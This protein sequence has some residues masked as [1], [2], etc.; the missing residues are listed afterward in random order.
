MHTPSIALLGSGLRR[1]Y[2][3]YFAAQGW[4]QR[5]RSPRTSAC[6]G[7]TWSC[8]ACRRASLIVQW[9][10][11]Y[12]YS[13]S[14]RGSVLPAISFFQSLARETFSGTT[15]RSTCRIFRNLPLDGR[16]RFPLRETGCL[17]CI[18]PGRCCLCSTF[19]APCHTQKQLLHSSVS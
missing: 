7:L 10:R 14:R 17:R 19:R 9:F 18:S 1:M 8:L 6:L 3:R 4:F 13:C 5:L 11:R 12:E 16:L 15:T 2:S